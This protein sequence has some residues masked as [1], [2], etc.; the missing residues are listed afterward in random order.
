MPL[1]LLALTI[2][3]AAALGVAGTASAAPGDLDTSFTPPALNSVVLPVAELT[4]GKY[5]IGGTSPMPA[6]T[7]TPTTWRG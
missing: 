6:A 7:R 5:L 1:R 4:G 2:T 3:A